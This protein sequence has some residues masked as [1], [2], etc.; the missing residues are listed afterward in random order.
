MYS[1]IQLIEQSVS[2]IATVGPQ[3]ID[4]VNTFPSITLLR[5]STQRRSI[6]KRVVVD[7]MTFILRAYTYTH[8][9]TSMDDIET[10]ARSIEQIVQSIKSPLIYS[11]R[12]TSVHTDEGLFAPYAICD[13]ECEV[14]WLNEDL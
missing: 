11:A 10:L 12:V 6:G 7:S 1:R 8:I 5:N 9:D 13:V 3:Y 2:A 4:D 14:N